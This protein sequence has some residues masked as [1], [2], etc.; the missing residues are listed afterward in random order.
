MGTLFIVGTPLGN[1][2]DI[3]I[4][5]VKTLFTVDVIACEDTRRAG[6]LLEKLTP[7]YEMLVEGNVK[8]VKPKFLSYYDAVEMERIPEIISILQTGQTIALISDAGMP[9]ISDPG[10]KLIRACIEQKIPIEVVP[11]PTAVTTAVAISGLPSDKF[12]FVGYPPHKPGHRITFYENIKKTQELVKSTVIFYEAPHKLLKTLEEMQEILGDREI[13]LCR[14]LTKTYEEVRREVISKAI[15]HFK[16]HEPKGE[17]V[18]L[19]NFNN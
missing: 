12:L 11:G 8:V 15:A 14:E 9:T 3:S 13:V 4:R 18:V 7:L 17:I 16:K 10:F 6:L 1:I 2:Q 19:I 5:A